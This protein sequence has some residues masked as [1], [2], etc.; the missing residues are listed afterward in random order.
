MTRVM[1]W[2]WDK[3]IQRRLTACEKQI[4][5]SAIRHRE[6]YRYTGSEEVRKER[7]S[8]PA[9]GSEKGKKGGERGARRWEA[10]PR[11]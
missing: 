2:I 1:R 11:P 3:P 9:A 6:S 8:R 10:R 4:T 5:G 7:R